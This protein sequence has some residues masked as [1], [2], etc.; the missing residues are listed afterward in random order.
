MNGTHGDQTEDVAAAI[1]LEAG[2]MRENELNQ[3]SGKECNPMAC[4]YHDPMLPG[5]ITLLLLLLLRTYMNTD[6]TGMPA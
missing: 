2:K 5:V 1:R 6:T 3:E 4:L